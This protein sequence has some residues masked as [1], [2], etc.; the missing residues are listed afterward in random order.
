MMGGQVKMSKK[1]DKEIRDYKLIDETT[2]FAIKEA[3]HHLRTNITYIP[4]EN[5]GCPIFCVTS[6]LEAVGK[7]TITAN[8]ALSFAS[9]GVKVLL[10][11]AD[12]RRPVIHNF[13]KI[14]PSRHG[15]TELISGI[16]KDDSKVAIPY[17]KEPDLNIISSG[18]V[19]RNPSELISSKKF[20][21]YLNKWK[22]EYDMILIDFPPVDIVPDALAVSNIATGY[23][24]VVRSGKSD[25]R[26]VSAAIAAIE[27][28]NAKVLGI[29]LNDISYKSGGSKYGKYGKYGRYG[30][31]YSSSYAKAAEEAES[32]ED[33]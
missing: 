9:S 22:F 12:I 17:E 11:D 8:I 15:L 7:S 27:Q 16:E 23:F 2:P 33:K 19:P 21:E 14:D 1:I 13:F 18:F 5:E 25:T 20:G 24:L 10:I 26:N 29:V 3:I 4:S 28:V 30:S 31:G 32:K 6:S